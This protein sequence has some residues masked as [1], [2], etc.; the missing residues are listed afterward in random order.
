MRL[1]LFAVLCALLMLMSAAASAAGQDASADLLSAREKLSAGDGDVTGIPLTLDE[2]LSLKEE[3]PGISLRC[4]IPVNEFTFPSD[5]EVIDFGDK[6]VKKAKELLKAL[7]LF[8][9]L[10]EADM[11]A[12][13]F[14]R[15]DMEAL[16]TARP[17][18]HWGWTLRLGS[19][20]LRTDVEAFSSLH[21]PTT[22]H[23][24]SAYY[25]PLKYCWRIKALDLGHNKLTDISFIGGMTDLRVLILADNK[26]KDISP[27]ANLKKLQYVELFMNK[28][29]DLSPLS[30]M[31]HLLDL[32]IC[33][34]SFS[35]IDEVYTMPK[36][37][38]LWITSNKRMSTEYRDALI[39]SLPNVEICYN[40]RG[41][42]GG[43]W[44]EHPRY[45]TLH[46]M[47][48]DRETHIYIPFEEAAE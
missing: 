28:I 39:A 23:Y 27:L 41:S 13:R 6:D 47:F 38:R 19:Y 32:N 1:R 22:T 26:I 8:T 15:E 37:E 45:D 24:S 25:S 16:W 31:E 44:R 18:V 43:G 9:N 34:N 33:Y 30:G 11:Y 7:P 10:K 40:C 21:S 2:L 14:S 17:D 48:A 3:F 35:V 4:D 42:T 36:L 20:K 5:A 29:S 12:C 46:T